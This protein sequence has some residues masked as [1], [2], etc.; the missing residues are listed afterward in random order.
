MH[1]LPHISTPT[2][3][4]IVTTDAPA[5]TRHRHPESTVGIRVHPEC[6][7]FRGFARLC[8]DIYPLLRDHKEEFHCS[9]NPP[10]STS[11]SPR[12]TNPWQPLIFG[13]HSLA[14]SKM[15]RN[16]NHVAFSLFRPDS[17]TGMC[18]EGSSMSFH[19]SVAHFCFG[20]STVP[21]SGCAAV[22]PFT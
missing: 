15:S 4:H 14:F 1:S 21:S 9:K 8:D 7:S 18:I 11:A 10:C 13:L 3:W 6:C 22:Y 16:W 2:R 20:L 19:G 5:V 17:F 12:P